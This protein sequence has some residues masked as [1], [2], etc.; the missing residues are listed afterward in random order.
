MSIKVTI[1]GTGTGVDTLTG[2]ADAEGLT[3]SFE[4]EQPAFLS[5]KSFK[6]LLS[7]KSAQSVKPQSAM[8]PPARVPTAQPVGNGNP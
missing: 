7:F 1:L 4:N 6:Q 3:V 8:T 5:W 2:K